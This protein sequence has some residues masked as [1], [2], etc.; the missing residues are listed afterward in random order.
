MQEKVDFDAKKA[1]QLGNQA[2]LLFVL[3]ER[4]IISYR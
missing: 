3:R 4:L 2:G 1:P